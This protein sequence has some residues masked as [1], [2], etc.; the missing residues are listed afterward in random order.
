MTDIEARRKELIAIWNDSQMS[1]EDAVDWVLGNEETIRAR[2]ATI[3]S[4]QALV[5]E[6]AHTD[7]ERAKERASLQEQVESLESALAS[8]SALFHPDCAVSEPCEA[9]KVIRAALGEVHDD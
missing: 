7:A 4:L 5:L 6:Q 2:Q 8:A 9:H 3:T 1:T